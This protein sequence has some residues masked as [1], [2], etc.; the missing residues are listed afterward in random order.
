MDKVVLIRL[1]GE[2]TLKSPGILRAWIN[3]LIKNI[4]KRLHRKGLEK[5]RITYR[6]GRIF[7]EAD[8]DIEKIHSETQKVFGVKETILCIRIPNDLDSIIGTAVELTRNWAGT[9]AVRTNRIKEYPLTSLEVNRIVGEK[10]LEANRNLE[11]DLTNPDNELEIEIR[12]NYAYVFEKKIEGFGG[13]PYGVSGKGVALVSGGIDSSL[14]AWLMMKRGMRIVAVHADLSPYYSEDAKKRF[15]DA[16]DWLRD[17]VPSGRLK[18][19]IVPIGDIHA[20]IRLPALKYRCIFC[21]MLMLKIAEYISRKE[22][23]HAIIT[24]EV[25]SQVASQTPVNMMAIDSVVNIPV[26]RPIVF[27]DKDE[28][29]SLAQKIGLY[30]IVA[31]DVGKCKLVP[32]RPVIEIDGETAKAIAN[33]ITRSIISDA[34]S[35]TEKIY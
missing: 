30:D 35:K 8:K 25:L 13:L 15:F 32:K 10:I 23:A 31:R 20:N 28:I 4:R 29:D 11:V 24:G 21:K 22:K 19:Y 9:F 18:T 1:S 3:T 5:T 33:L 26:L 2:I 17:W 16:L 12:E 7:I 6:A 14:A 34:L 27:M